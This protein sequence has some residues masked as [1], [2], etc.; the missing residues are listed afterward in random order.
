M[1]LSDSPTEAGENYYN[2][3][4]SQDV[5]IDEPTVNKT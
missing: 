4:S 3:N 5:E 1:D 2:F